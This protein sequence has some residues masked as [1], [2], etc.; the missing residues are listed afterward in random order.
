M[1]SPLVLLLMRICS[2]QFSSPRGIYLLWELEFVVWQCC[3][4]LALQHEP[5]YPEGHG[6]GFF[7][8]L[9]IAERRHADS[10][11]AL[12]GI[13]RDRTKKR[14]AATKDF[15]LGWSG[16]L[17]WR[18]FIGPPLHELALKECME[19]IAALEWAQWQFYLALADR[20]D[21]ALRK[22]LLAIANEE[23]IHSA[24]AG[25]PELHYFRRAPWAIA[26]LLLWDLPR[27][28]WGLWR[29]YGS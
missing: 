19:A 17:S 18:F 3:E 2:R 16:I 6:S 21:G 15:G 11:A 27:L 28:K 8:E 23:L 29:R 4:R 13:A 26:I 1:K 9:A 14:A 20:C 12:C 10:L 22:T 5:H 25:S 7:W 24:R